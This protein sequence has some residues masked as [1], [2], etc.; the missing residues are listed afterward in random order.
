[1][2]FIMPS[3]LKLFL[4]PFETIKFMLLDFKAI[5]DLTLTYI[6]TLISSL[7]YTVIVHPLFSNALAL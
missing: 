3:G 5:H 2:A 4:R 7:Q 6:L 1:M